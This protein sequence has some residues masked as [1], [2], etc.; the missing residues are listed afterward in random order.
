MAQ[1]VISKQAAWAPASDRAG[2]RTVVWWAGLGA[3]FVALQVVI[4]ARWLASDDFRTIRAD[5][6]DM[7]G[8]TKVA[9]IVAQVGLTAG[10][11]LAVIWVGRRCW[12]ERRLTL[13]GM[14]VLGSFAVAWQDA[15]LNYTRT[16]FIYNSYMINVG[17][18]VHQ[19][20]GWISPN[21]N[22]VPE[23]IF[24]AFPGYV[25]TQVPVMLGICALL[26]AARNRRPGISRLQL[27]GLACL[28]A[29]L[30]DLLLEVGFT[31]TGVYSYMGAIHGL[32]LFGGRQHQFPLYAAVLWGLY[33][34]FVS[35][36]R[37]AVDD[38]GRSILEGGADRL[39]V[40]TRGQTA[41]R[42]LAVV[43]AMNLAFI[44][45]V[46]GLNVANFYA[47][48]APDSIPSYLRNGVCGPGTKYKCP[49]PDVP[50]LLRGQ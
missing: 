33:W 41:V 11:L 31:R 30:I 32:S 45:Y 20:P 22:E 39:T 8:Y 10:C 43:G 44:G 5:T 46:G 2:T 42:A 17:T 36:L 47:G 13:D 4:Y 35:Y 15:L 1:A 7:P 49:G 50:I 38:R 16:G 6:T 28:T 29:G 12:R 14:I 37:F 19:I 18:W 21:G 3:F 25:A 23:G 27:F 9:C 34:G 26:R 40:G 48:E 24:W